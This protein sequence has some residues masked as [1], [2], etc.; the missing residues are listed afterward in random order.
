MMKNKAINALIKMGMPAE[1]KGFRYIVD[2][3][4]LFNP[5]YNV[6]TIYSVVA[7]KNNTTPSR[8]ER[9]IRHAFGAV[10]TDGAPEYVDAYLTRN[11]TTN[12][13]LLHVLYLRLTQEE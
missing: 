1:I 11:H 9:A 7:Q 5:D 13:N 8:V 12:G 3:M 4:C 6:T 2:A 10:L